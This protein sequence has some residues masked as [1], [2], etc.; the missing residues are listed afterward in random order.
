M[1]SPPPLPL[2]PTCTVPRHLP[3]GKTAFASSSPC[4]AQRWT[5]MVPSCRADPRTPR[6]P[7]AVVEGLR[8]VVS[9]LFLVLP[10]SVC[11]SIAG[12]TFDSCRTSGSESGRDL[13]GP[14][15]GRELHPPAVYTLSRRRDLRSRHN[16]LSRAGC[17]LS[18]AQRSNDPES[19]ASKDGLL[20][21]HCHVL[22]ARQGVGGRTAGFRKEQGVRAF[23]LPIAP[24]KGDSTRP[25]T[26]PRLA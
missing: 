2:R 25:Y 9:P 23:R 6:E 1:R 20:V 18:V 10:S 22:S 13:S 26:S 3:R 21:G 8:L 11:N 14:T 12:N 5:A 19:V 7:S 15:I 24:A 4:E 16:S 17:G